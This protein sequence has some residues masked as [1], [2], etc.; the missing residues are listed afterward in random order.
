MIQSSGEII[1]MGPRRKSEVLDRTLELKTSPSLYA[2]VGDWPVILMTLLCVLAVLL[3]A[4]KQ[5]V[6]AAA[7]GTQD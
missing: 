5:V 6:G 2:T 3:P 4:R 1:S 7:T